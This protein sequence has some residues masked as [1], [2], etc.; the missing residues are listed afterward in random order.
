[1]AYSRI[2]PRRG[3]LYE[4]TSVNPIIESGELVVEVPDDGVG[5]GLSK[6]KIGDGVKT[7]KQL[8]YAFDGQAAASIIG[9]TSTESTANLISLRDDTLE[10]W[11]TV[12][13]VLSTGEVVYDSTNN[14]LK[15][16]DGV[17]AWK[18]LKYIKASEEVSG[19]YDFGNEDA[20]EVTSSALYNSVIDN[21]KYPEKILSTPVSASAPVTTKKTSKKKSSDK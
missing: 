4:W 17:T 18:S 2:R 7:Y 6:F 21:T 20:E 11:N 5:T 13:P 16:G 9:G 1:M 12:N 8:P 19:D 10:K 14:S 15:V 3:T